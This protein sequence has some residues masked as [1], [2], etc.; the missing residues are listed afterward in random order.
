MRISEQFSPYLSG[1]DRLNPLGE[2]L[3]N[4]E[5]DDDIDLFT[6]NRSRDYSKDPKAKPPIHNPVFFKKFL[7]LL[8]I[9]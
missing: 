7:L 6:V 9:K 4:D 3:L 8:F 5:E 2:H 1:E